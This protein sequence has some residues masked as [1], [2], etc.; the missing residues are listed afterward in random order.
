MK[1]ILRTVGFVLCSISVQVMAVRKIIKM[2]SK[3]KEE[4]DKYYAFYLLTNQWLRLKQSA[5]NLETFFMRNDYRK[6]AIYG[7]NHLGENLYRELQ[8]TGV[9]VSYAIDKNA[10]NL[11]VND[12]EVLKPWEELPD[13]DAVIVTPF[14][15]FKEIHKDLEKKLKCPIVS[16]ED[17]I[18]SLDD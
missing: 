6:I 3:S 4:A 13:V 14:I 1:K 16:L 15:Y 18:Y 5:R 2:G 17:I 7:M 10:D 8:G 9:E 11:Y 12:C